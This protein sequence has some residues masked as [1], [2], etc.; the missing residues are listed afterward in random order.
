MLQVC[1]LTFPDANFIPQ[2][3]YSAYKARYVKDEASNASFEACSDVFEAC[4]PAFANVNFVPAPTARR[5]IKGVIAGTYIRC[6]RNSLCGKNGSKGDSGGLN[7][8]NGVGQPGRL[9]PIFPQKNFLL[10]RQAAFR[11]N[12]CYNIVCA[13]GLI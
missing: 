10:L 8:K 2:A 5:R 11:P 4:S 1:F 9:S 12:E 3:A 6:L 13:E 7:T